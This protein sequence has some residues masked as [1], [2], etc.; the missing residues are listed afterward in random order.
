MQHAAARFA[1]EHRA[2]AH[3]L[4]AGVLN[5]GR[6]VFGDLCVD[7]G[8]DLSGDRVENVFKG[9]A[10]DDAFAQPF[11]DVARLGD[12][13]RP[14]AFDGSAIGFRDDHV[15]RHVNQT[16]RQVARIGGLERRVGQAFARAV[17]GDEVLQHVQTLAEIGADRG[18]DDFARRLGHQ[19][20]HTGELPDLLLVTAR[21]GIGHDQDRI[22][23][24]GFLLAP[25]HFAEHL[26]GDLFGHFRPDGD[27]LVVAFAVSDHAVLVLLLDFDHFV[28]GV[29]DQGRFA[30]RRDHVVNADRNA[31][32]RRVEES[33]LFQAVEHLDGDLMPQAQKAVVD[34][35]LQPFLLERAVDVRHF[36]RKMV[37][38]HHAPDGRVDRAVDLADRGLDHVLRVALGVEVDQTA[39][40]PQADLGLCGDLLGVEREHHLI[41]RG[42]RAAL[43]L[44][45]LH[46]AGHV[47]TAEH[48]VL[49][50]HGDGLP[51][52]RRQDVVR[53]EHQDLRLDLR[54]GRERDVDGHLVAVEVR[55][56]GRADERVNLDRLALDQHR[57]ERLDAQA[58][59]R[60]RAVEQHRV[61]LDHLFEDVPDHVVVAL[62]HLLGLLDRRGVAFGFE[63]V[64]D[65]RLEQL[66]GHLLRQAALVQLAARGRRRSP[67]GPNNRRACPAGSGGSA[68]VYP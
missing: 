19:A 8:Q 6:H 43:A 21:A 12:R 2:D 38:E 54:L 10:A 64:V 27:D 49:R 4:D 45:A 26:V 30:R 46:R 52:S 53:R 13:L 44:R 3:A 18:L 37:V 51:R 63:P 31:G 48:D 36:F 62:D 29:R 11:D 57:L 25:L 28:L 9:D 35:A 23:L 1:G 66:Q 16:A 42:E 24:A 61:I 59:E 33:E 22:Q 55:V 34:Q 65:E 68:P 32:L 47:V 50:R 39:F 60:R 41:R 15:L 17:R 40:V 7:P 67:N 14:D 20:A 58:V 56:E 5:L